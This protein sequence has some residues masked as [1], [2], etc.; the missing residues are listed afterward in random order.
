MNEMS[1][2]LGLQE[3][4]Q[5]AGIPCSPYFV[6]R[7]QNRK[8]SMSFRTLFLQEMIKSGVII[9]YIA[10]SYAHTEA[11]VMQTLS[12]GEKA[13]QIYQ[14]ALEEGIEKYLKGSPIKPVF[15]IFN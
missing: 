7:D 8:I 3:H 6:C 5:F 9:N 13:L 15:R 4:V 10:P 2:D 1:S 14:R 11:I 12:A